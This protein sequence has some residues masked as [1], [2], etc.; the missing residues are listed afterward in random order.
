MEAMPRL[1][2]PGHDCLTFRP[3]LSVAREEMSFCKERYQ[4]R[5][6]IKEA[7]VGSSAVDFGKKRQFV[8]TQCPEF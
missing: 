8:R 3:L 2:R 4:H 7:M 5:L 6:H 1:K